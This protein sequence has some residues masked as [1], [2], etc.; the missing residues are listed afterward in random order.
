MSLNA[1]TLIV[2]F[3]DPLPCYCLSGSWLCSRVKLTNI[4]LLERFRLEGSNPKWYCPYEYISIHFLSSVLS[5]TICSVVQQQ[6][7]CCPAPFWPPERSRRV[8]CPF[9]D[10]LTSGQRLHFLTMLAVSTNQ[11][12]LISFFHPSRALSTSSMR[13]TVQVLTRSLILEP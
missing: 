12:R 10:R 8:K 3:Y 9:M 2:S 11:A 13:K 6:P 7:S 5:P 4:N 1:H